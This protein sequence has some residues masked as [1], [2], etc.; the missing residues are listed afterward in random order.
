MQLNVTTDCYAYFVK[1]TVPIA[2]VWLSDNYFDLLPGEERVIEVVD[3]GGRDL[4]EAD[5]S[6]SCL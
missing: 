2:G 3:E 4:R 1:I 6:V 5:I